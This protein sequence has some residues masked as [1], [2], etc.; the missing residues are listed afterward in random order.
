[1]RATLLLLAGFTFIAP[2][3]A[4]DPAPTCSGHLATIEPD[5]SV[6]NGSK[7][8][9]REAVERGQPIR[10]GWALDWNEDGKSDI[11]HW[12]D[13]RFLSIFEDEIFTQ[14]PEIRRQ[15]PQPGKSD[16]RLGSGSEEWAGLIG[17][18]GRMESQF[19]GEQAQVYPVRSWWCLDP[20]NKTQ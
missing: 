3:W 17:T 13:A 2:A 18:T 9:L 1:M 6:S 16:I 8:A 11:V 7:Q 4:N 10:I 20:R 12:A 19:K 14:T 5:G 15:R